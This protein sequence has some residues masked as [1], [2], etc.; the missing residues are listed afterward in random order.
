MKARKVRRASLGDGWM[1][2]DDGWMM[3]GWINEDG[4]WIFEA[5]LWV[6]LG[7]SSTFYLLSSFSFAFVLWCSGLLSFLVFL[8]SPVFSRLFLAS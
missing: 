6:S 5:A 4:G 7:F 8:P 2:M 3:D 1:R